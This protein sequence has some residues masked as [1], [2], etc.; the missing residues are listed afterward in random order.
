M[1][2]SRTAERDAAGGKKLAPHSLMDG[3][4]RP[5]AGKICRA[6]RTGGAL[7]A[8]P[9]VQPINTKILIKMY[10]FK[11]ISGGTQPAS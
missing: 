9:L 11:F 2:P 3:F 4:R 5:P 8:G 6:R 7:I 10:F 1:I